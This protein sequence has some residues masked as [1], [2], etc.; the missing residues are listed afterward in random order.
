MMGSTRTTIDRHQWTDIVLGLWACCVA[1]EAIGYFSG[2]RGRFHVES[3]LLILVAGGILAAAWQRRPGGAEAP[4]PAPFRTRAWMPLSAVAAALALYSSTLGIGFLSDDFALIAAGRHGAF[5]VEP[6]RFFRPLAIGLLSALGDAPFAMHDILVVLHGLNAFLVFR[7]ARVLGASPLCALSAAALFIT[8]PAAVEAV[9]W[10]SGI[11]DVLLATAGLVFVLVWGFECSLRLRLVLAVAA[12][13][14]GLGTKE[15]AVVFP[16]LALTVWLGS[17][18][19]S[20]RE[21][22]WLGLVTGAAAGS[23]ALWRLTWPDAHD[24]AQAPSRWLL[25][26]L[27]SRTFGGL[28][29]PWHRDLGSAG[30]LLGSATGAFLP[31]ALV[32]NLQLWRERPAAFARVLRL[33]AWALLST[34][35]A[36]GLLFVSADLGGSRYLYLAEAAGAI[37]AAELWIQA[38]GRVTR[39]AVLVALPIFVCVAVCAAAL[40]VHLRPW[41]EAARL[42]DTT[43]AAAQAQL[44]RLGCGHAAFEGL[45]DSVRGAYV[46]RNGF[47][48][49]LERAWPGWQADDRGSSCVLAWSGSGFEAR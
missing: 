7:L 29:V 41:Q 4:A 35:P 10:C 1:G 21:L 11:Q 42:R 19:L 17:P 8:F 22:L 27:V 26:E 20:R 36:Y 5:G 30:V 13:S 18:R 3:K 48:A 47:G 24:Y 34:A 39:N 16:A 49:A 31:L 33:A 46:F 2:A 37:L 45:P 12:L 44:Q 28:T 40:R 32:A 6:G 23:F 38:A 43:L 25:K 14:V 9:A 15:T